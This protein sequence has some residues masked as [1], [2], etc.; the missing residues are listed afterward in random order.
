MVV[1]VSTE[2]VAVP[3]LEATLLSVLLATPLFV[4]L[5]TLLDGVLTLFPRE[6][7]AAPTAVLLAAFVTRFV[8]VLDAA[9]AHPANRLVTNVTINRFTVTFVR[10]TPSWCTYPFV[11]RTTYLS[12]TQ[13]LKSII[14]VS[15]MHFNSAATRPA[16][17]YSPC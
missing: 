12:N 5:A 3:L 17:Q 15:A 11:S 1:L 16:N 2:L 8:S 14:L 9:F 6:F 4:L 7:V 13:L 10:S